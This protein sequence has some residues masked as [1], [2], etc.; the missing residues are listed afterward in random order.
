MANRNVARGVRIALLAAGAA[1]AGLHAPSVLAQAQE[2]E[3]IVV[4][5][6]RIARAELESNAPLAL[7]SSADIARTGLV[8]VGDILQNLSATDGTGLRPITTAT[9][10]SDGASQISL[11]NLG[12]ERTLI[13]VDG[14]RWVTDGSNIVD[15]NTIP[16]SMIERVE[17]LKDGAS[18]IYGSDAIAGVINI[19]TK[20]QFDGLQLDAYYGVTERGDG[21]QDNYGITVG[22]SGERSNVILGINY[23]SQEE[24]MA[25][26]RKI[27]KVSIYG[28]SDPASLDAF[29][30]FCGSGTGQYGRFFVTGL[31]GSYTLRPGA[32]GDTP[33]DFNPWSNAARYNFAPVN[34]LQQPVERT[35]VFASGNMELTDH[36]EAYTK[37]V[38]TKIQ[39][40]QQL[41][42]VPAT[43]AV[44]GSQGPQW[45]IPIAADQYFNPWD[46]AINQSFWRAVPV[47]P[48]NPTYDYDTYGINLG[49]KGDFQA[50]AR[51]FNWDVGLQYNDG[52]YDNVGN[53]YINLF[54]LRNALGPSFRD[55]AG[56]LRCGTPGNVIRGCVPLNIFGGPDLGVA[57]G[58]VTPEEAE[59]MI[60]YIGYTQVSTAGLTSTNWYGDI[61]SEIFDLPAGPL[62]IAVGMEYRKN[63]YFNQPDTLVASGGSSDNFQ[64]P[65]KGTVDVTE[66]Y[67]EI[68]IPLLKDL[69]GAQE[70]T[71]NAANR[72]SDYSTYGKV[73]LQKIETEP[74]SPSTSKLNLVWRPIDEVMV[75]GSWGET[76]RAPSVVDLYSG[77]GE[78]FPQASDPCRTTNWANLSVDAR[79][80]CVADNVPVGGVV[81]TNTQIRALVGGNPFL[82]PEEG[83]NYSFGVVWEPSFVDNLSLTIDYWNIA[84]EQAIQTFGAGTVLSRC[85]VS[86]DLAYCPFVERISTGE[87]ATVRTAGF[88]A[89]ERE[90]DGI[91]FSV[92]YSFDTERYGTFGFQWDTT[93]TMSDKFKLSTS[94]QFTEYTG[95][96]DGEVHWEWRS[97]LVT[98]WSLGDL[99]AAWTMRYTSE[100]E[101][102]CTWWTGL[103][104]TDAKGK[105][106]ICSDPNRVQPNDLA[107][108]FGYDPDDNDVGVNVLDS[109]VYHDLQVSYAAPWNGVFTVGG[110]NIFGTEPP[111]VNN[112]FAHS[113]DGA[114][115]LPGGAYWYASYKQNF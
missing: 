99:S 84:L 4:T 23:S 39:S 8:N 60:N 112:S 101:E 45:T 61:S 10:G 48:R 59:Q 51:T 14:R 104:A 97:N 21:A 17:V 57:A 85:Y 113:F 3:Q 69:P 49:V 50:M 41:A 78:S 30:G 16:A 93:Y 7:V 54:N 25:G 43:M 28:C 47:G 9:N 2:L 11:R 38:Y 64:E 98:T 37:V 82:E 46:A 63:E 77:G 89:A 88:N 67:V 102:D 83:E 81:Q 95:F 66:Y 12:A 105:P 115:D 114:Y 68:N 1:T 94:S 73:G 107:D 32:A 62:G 76:F 55:T 42:D 58:V 24:I 111:T 72:W 18:A 75:R 65:T 80:R 44:N 56:V 70:L 33:D 40:A 29:G 106:V 86:G 79:A 91:D 90:A 15:L 96:Y 27:S 92:R 108:F 5:G 52:Q 109:K 34:Y 87:I 26:D 36:I 53:N 31:P 13:L 100:L 110:R 35:N 103:G 6:S 22:A 74:G 20:K 71:L 19:I